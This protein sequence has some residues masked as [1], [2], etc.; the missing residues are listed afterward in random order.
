MTISSQRQAERRYV[1]PPSEL[2]NDKDLPEEQRQ[3]LIETMRNSL[4]ER[5]KKHGHQIGS[6]HPDMKT[7][8][9]KNVDCIRYVK[10]AIADG[11]EAI[12][13][14]ETARKIHSFHKGTDLAR[15]L[16]SRGWR[17]VYYNS[18][19]DDEGE[20]E[21]NKRTLKHVNESNAYFPYDPD[22]R[23]NIDDK[24]LDYGV[25]SNKYSQAVNDKITQEDFGFVNA[26]NGTHTALLM[27]GAVYEVHRNKEGFNE[28]PPDTPESEKL[29][30]KQD[31]NRW[32]Q[33]KG[34]KKKQGVVMLPPLAR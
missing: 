7:S 10:A 9:K 12:G 2:I 4:Y 31:F 3:K 25:Q 24:W 30:E 11:Y 19:T 14:P 18:E 16:K 5:Y 33:S 32:N 22:W 1:A 34:E 26:N 17:A 6:Q 20:E 8:P 28:Y 15:Y 13:M 21:Q 29:Y 23:V 27:N